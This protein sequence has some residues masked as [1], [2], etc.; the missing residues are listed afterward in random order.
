MYKLLQG[1]R[2]IEGG[3]FIAAP[4]CGLH[5]LQMGAEVIRFD[6][7]GGGPDYNRWPLAPNG[8]SL[9]WEGLNKGKKSVAVDLSSPEGRELISSIIAAPSHDGLFVTNFPAAGFLS[10]ERLRQR[11]EDLIVLR[12][13]G[14][15]DGGSAVDYTVNCAYGVPH[16]TGPES[17]G[18]E[19]VNHVLPAWDL[20]TGAYAAFSLLAAERYRSNTGLGQEI[21]VP[22]DDVAI[23]SLGHL[24]QIAETCIGTG[25]RGRYG[26]NL[27]GAFGRDFVTRDGRRL[28][29]VAITSRQWAG[30][31][32][33][34]GI[35][36]EIARAESSAGVSFADDEGQRFRFREL[37]NPIVE[38]AVAGRD[39]SELVD[40]LN[41][42]GCCHGTYRTISQAIADDPALSE[43]NP[44]LSSVRHPSGYSYLTPGAAAS[45]SAAERFPPFRAPQLGEHT[46]EILADTL[47]LSSGQIADLHDRKVV[48]GPTVRT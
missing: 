1:L 17:L 23:A 31:V 27:Y 16:M 39:Y 6:A 38:T 34:L 19:P 10:Y 36:D 40:A 37:L 47:G 21:R 12:V 14:R 9:Y 45:L 46:D 30:L 2:V 3:S 43:R 20:L 8:A 28:M 24:G 26:N 15:A 13:M 29:V 42:S 41:A 22:L 25:D 35:W 18:N 4:S 44:L 33:A 5:L 7:I 32:S 48:A 11:R